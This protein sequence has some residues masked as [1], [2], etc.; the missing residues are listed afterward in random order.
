MMFPAC[1]NYT[2]PS[3]GDRLSGDYAGF[4]VCSPAMTLSSQHLRVVRNERRGFPNAALSAPPHTEFYRKSLHFWQNHQGSRQGRWMTMSLL[5]AWSRSW[6]KV[7]A[8]DPL[9]KSWSDSPIFAF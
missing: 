3:S 4:L 2:T 1:L 9:M 7:G 5:L 6:V 8:G